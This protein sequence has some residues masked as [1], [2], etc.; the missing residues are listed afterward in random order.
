MPKE[1]VYVPVVEPKSTSY[2]EYVELGRTV[3]P[4]P[5]FKK[6]TVRVRVLQ[7]CKGNPAE[8]FETEKHWEYDIPW[9]AK[10]EVVVKTKPVR[11]RNKKGQYVKDDPS[12]VE[13]EA[14]VG[15]KAPSV[16]KAK[17]KAKK[18]NIL[19]NTLTRLGRK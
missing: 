4:C 15:G 9:S 11:V 5:V 10:E 6:D 17:R 19:E 16:P 3:T 13:N 12:T 2:L 1:K 14:W 8:T 7:I 18:K